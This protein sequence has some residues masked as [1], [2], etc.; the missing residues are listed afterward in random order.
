MSSLAKLRHEY[1]QT[2]ERLEAIKE[3]IV[4][5]CTAKF[6]T[7]DKDNSNTISVGEFLEYFFDKTDGMNYST[8]RKL[9]D[10]RMDRFKEIDTDH[11]GSLTLEEVIDFQ[12][13]KL[14]K[15]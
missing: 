13:G 7:R 15:K 6:A 12:L 3:E 8:I 9:L 2:H 14:V 11:N 5:E 4:Q 10:E 1:Q